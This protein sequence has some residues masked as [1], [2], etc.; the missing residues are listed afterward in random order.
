MGTRDYITRFQIAV[1]DRIS[2]RLIVDSSD[3]RVTEVVVLAVP[4]GR[5]MTS[6]SSSKSCRFKRLKS[7]HYGLRVGFDSVEKSPV[8][9]RH[10]LGEVL[11]YFRLK[12]L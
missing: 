12:Y 6:L 5:R 7:I 2:F 10:L 8:S 4:A 11:R 3:N 1:G 9:R